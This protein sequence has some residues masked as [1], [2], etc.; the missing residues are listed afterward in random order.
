MFGGKYL[1]GLGY[2]EPAVYVC[3]SSPYSWYTDSHFPHLH[4]RSINLDHLLV[5][6]GQS[7]KLKR[8]A[9]RATREEL[10]AD[11]SV[12]NRSRCIEACIRPKWQATST[13]SRCRKLFTG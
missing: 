11:E 10:T 1:A 2:F 7:R 5:S 6:A 3:T 8:A 9:E 4:Q 12:R 13:L